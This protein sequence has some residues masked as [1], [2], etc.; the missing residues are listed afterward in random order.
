MSC[1]LLVHI[2][3]SGLSVLPVMEWRVLGAQEWDY[4]DQGI[5]DRGREQAIHHARWIGRSKQHLP[6]MCPRVSLWTVMSLSWMWLL[7]A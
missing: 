5:R 7:A 6:Y 3:L 4:S 1:H 2:A